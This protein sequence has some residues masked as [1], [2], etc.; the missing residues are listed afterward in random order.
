MGNN[1]PNVPAL[2]RQMKPDGTLS[3]RS[4]GWTIGGGGTQLQPNIA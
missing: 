3:S 1:Y 4:F 2:A